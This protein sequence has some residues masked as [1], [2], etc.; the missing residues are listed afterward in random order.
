MHWRVLPSPWAMPMPNL[1]S[2]PSRAI[3]SVAIWPV[4]RKARD[5]GPC[6]AWIARK[7]STIVREGLVPAHPA[8]DAARVAAERR[9]G[10]VAGFQHRQSLPALGAG[11]AAVHGVVGG[12]GEADRLAVPEV[13]G[14]AAAGGAVAAH[15]V[16]GGVGLQAGRHLPEPEAARRPQ[17]I[18][19]EVSVALVEHGYRVPGIRGEAT[20]AKNR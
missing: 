5:S 10:A 1:A 20:A 3:S 16:R 13:H 15:H 12:R 2:A 7:R 9:R 17:Q 18:A 11:D 14:Q 6:S 4:L 8:L 19:G